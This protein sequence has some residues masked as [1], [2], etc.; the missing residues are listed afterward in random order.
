[1]SFWDVGCGSVAQASALLTHMACAGPDPRVTI[2]YTA[3]SGRPASAAAPLSLSP[4]CVAALTL[5][6]DCLAKGFVLWQPYVADLLALVTK[7]H[8]LALCSQ[9]PALAAAASRAFTQIGRVAPKHLVN[10]M[11]REA[12]AKPPSAS[13]APTLSSHSPAPRA[14]TLP[15][16]ALT[17]LHLSAAPDAPLAT[18]PGAALAAILAVAARHPL[19]LYRSVPLIAQVLVRCLDPV[20]PNLRRAL[21]PP[22]TRALHTLVSTY[23]TIAFDQ[24]SQRVAVAARAPDPSAPAAPAAA[25]DCGV[26]LYDLRTATRIRVLL[27]HHA[28]VLALA[29]SPSGAVLLSYAREEV[30]FWAVGGSGLLASLL[31]GAGRCTQAQTLQA[32]RAQ[33]PQA[34]MQVSVTWETRAVGKQMQEVAVLRREDGSVCRFTA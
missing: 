1:L 9:H 8:Y 27:G 7:L 30:R 2:T 23:A 11:A 14:S 21:L 13:P 19:A 31:G 16:A 25:D 24:H 34:V 22:A 5:A 18:D 32:C 15:A 26:V 6:V 3:P 28:P 29:F 12:V 10:A 17:A 20:R 4:S 33:G